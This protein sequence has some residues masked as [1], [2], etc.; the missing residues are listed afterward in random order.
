MVSKN[1]FVKIVVEKVIVNMVKYDIIVL[2]V[3]L[4]NVN[5]VN[6]NTIVKIV[7]EKV[8]ANIIVIK[9]IVH[10]VKGVWYVNMANENE[11]VLN[12]KD[13]VYVNMVHEKVYA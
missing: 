11:L 7:V 13:P 2:I 1:T 10:Y 3:V 5:M 8:I 4:L 6:K 9:R 12:A